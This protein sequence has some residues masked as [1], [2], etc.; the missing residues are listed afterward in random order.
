MSRTKIQ[1]VIEQWPDEEFIVVD[2]HDDAIIGVD[3]ASGKLVYDVYKIL[4]TLMDDGMT[5]NEAY[6]FY[7]YNILNAYF[8]EKTPLFVYLI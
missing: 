6:E 5:R 1:E 8:G 7:E 3:D 2:G 4:K